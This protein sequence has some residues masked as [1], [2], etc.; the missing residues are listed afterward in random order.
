MSRARWSARRRAIDLPVGI[1]KRVSGE[2]RAG[3]VAG[4]L[5]EPEPR[6]LTKASRHHAAVDQRA[7]VPQVMTLVERAAVAAGRVNSAAGTPAA[8]SSCVK[9]TSKRRPRI[10]SLE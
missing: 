5:G 1:P 2:P 3:Q 6:R 10:S 8:R 7:V 9:N 4:N